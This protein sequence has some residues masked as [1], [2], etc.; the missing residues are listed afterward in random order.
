MARVKD[1]T[2][3]LKLTKEDYFNLMKCAMAH[4]ILSSKT[5]PDEP[6]TARVYHRTQY[7]S[8]KREIAKSLS[9]TYNEV[10]RCFK[11]ADM[12]HPFKACWVALEEL[13]G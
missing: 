11:E 3:F 10:D 6:D 7:N 9:V 13:I 12:K 5:F 1:G 4:L 8:I 2:N